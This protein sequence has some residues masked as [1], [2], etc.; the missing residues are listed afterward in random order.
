MEKRFKARVTREA[1]FGWLN[2]LFIQNALNKYIER[3]HYMVAVA[4][5]RNLYGTSVSIP[6]H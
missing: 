2:F 6:W 3:R 5:A 4:F 1:F